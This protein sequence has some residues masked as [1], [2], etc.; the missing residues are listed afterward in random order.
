MQCSL[1]LYV[2]SVTL[3]NSLA[4]LMSQSSLVEFVRRV[5]VLTKLQQ[6]WTDGHSNVKLICSFTGHHSN[7]TV[8]CHRSD[9][10][11]SSSD[12]NVLPSLLYRSLP[13]D[14]IEKLDWKNESESL[15]CQLGADQYAVIVQNLSRQLIRSGRQ[16][17]DLLAGRGSTT[18]ST[19]DEA[20]IASDDI[21]GSSFPVDEP[22]PAAATRQ[23]K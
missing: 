20:A 2:H 22:P 10:G 23:S 21:V 14:L 4:L 7:E 19:E 9:E 16:R 1:E 13:A 15:S 3:C 17:K 5:S 11:N 18:S 12:H 6:C 8:D